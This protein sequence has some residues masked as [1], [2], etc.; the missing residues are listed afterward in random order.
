MIIFD[1]E[2]TGLPGVSALPED[3]QPEII[4]FGALKLNDD[5][6][7]EEDELHFMAKPKLVPKLDP[8]ITKITGITWFDLKDKAPFVRHIPE[9]TDFFLG[10]RKL[11]A[12]N[13]PF[14]RDL[15]LFE[16]RRVGREYMFP[17][18]PQHLCTV[19]L[20]HDLQ[21]KPSKQE[22]LYEHYMGKPAG[23]THRALDDCRQL[24]DIVRAMRK[25][26]RV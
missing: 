15:M 5:T 9:V 3:K 4:E 18:P 7:E 11:V 25:E 16:L 6:L 23:Q 2:T 14:D 1:T 12:H 21:G 10:E 22:W 17:W 8:V 13:L 19:E 24:A 20:T 26:G